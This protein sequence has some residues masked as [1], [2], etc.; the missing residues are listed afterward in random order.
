MKQTTEI[1]IWAVLMTILVLLTVF[2]EPVKA[3]SIPVD[4]DTI[5]VNDKAQIAEFKADLVYDYSTDMTHS[6][7]LDIQVD[8]WTGDNILLIFSKKNSKDGRLV[9]F[10][11]DGMKST[12]NFDVNKVV[13]KNGLRLPILDVAM[14][15]FL[16]SG[17][18]AIEIDDD[19]YLFNSATSEPFRKR[20]VALFKR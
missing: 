13:L 7:T 2:G 1:K 4:W 20:A 5:D 15:H 10:Y 12:V 19:M 16:N 8:D 3:Q 14:P 9:I 6:V 17:I 11:G 18:M